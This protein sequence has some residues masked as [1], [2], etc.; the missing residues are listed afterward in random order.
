MSLGGQLNGLFRAAHR[1]PALANAVSVALF[2]AFAGATTQSILLISL[3]MLLVHAAIGSSNDVVDVEDDRRTQPNKPIVLGLVSVE[4]V[5]IAA[6]VEG[7]LAL[8][9]ALSV[10]FGSFLV[11][12][13]ILISG[14]AYNFWAKRTILSWLPYAVFIPSVVTAG[15]FAADA[16]EPSVMIAYLIGALVAIALNLA[17]SIPDIEGDRANGVKS[18]ATVLGVRRSYFLTWTTLSL[19]IG[20]LWLFQFATNSE[21][22]MFL[23]LSAA[24]CVLAMV[25]LALRS[26]STDA[27]RMHWYM[28]AVCTV[29]IGAAFV[30]SIR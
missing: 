26:Q 8:I 19:S 20:G 22:P 16:Y 7:T 6:V 4:T 14:L 5:R 11:I 29:L 30:V 18:L 15:F 2:A 24:M 3:S 13:A 9:L 28:T 23:M 12:L 17:N 1:F 25:G 21:S 27:R 10:N